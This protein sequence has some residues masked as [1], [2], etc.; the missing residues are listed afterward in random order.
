MDAKKE[1]QKEQ[2][3]FDDFQ[4]WSKPDELDLDDLMADYEEGSPTVLPNPPPI[5]QI[6]I[7]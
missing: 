3:V 7:L 5:Q 1:K 6:D 4:Y 2:A